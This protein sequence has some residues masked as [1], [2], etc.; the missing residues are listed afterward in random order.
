MTNRSPL[1]AYE[2][3]TNPRTVAL[4]GASSNEGRLTARPQIFMNRH[5]FQGTIY[6]V[7]PNRKSVLG[8]PAFADV[9]DIPVPV[10]L[11]YIMQDTDAAI[12][13]F[14]ACAAIGVRV[15]ILLANGFSEVGAE[16]VERERRIRETADKHGVFLIGPN[17]T[18]V[19]ATRS[20]LSCTT[21][22]AFSVDSLPVGNLAVLSQSGSLIGTL[23]SRGAPRGI[24][25]S[26]F[27]SV[28]N[29]A[30]QTIGSIGDL[31]VDDPDT[32][33]F[34]LFLETIRD[35]S[36]FAS[37]ARKAYE[38]RKPV[39]AYVVG[40]SDEGKALSASHTG[41]MTGSSKAMQAFLDDNGIYTVSILDAL[42]DG[43]ATAMKIGKREN[44]RPSTV[45]VASTTGGGGAMV[46][47]KLSN[48]GVSVAGCSDEARDILTSRNVPLGKGKLLDVTLAGTN[49]ETM[50]DVVS[51]LIEDPSTG[52]LLVV[53]GSSAQF[54]PELAVRP[55]VDAVAESSPNASPVLA[56]PL[57]EAVDSLR[58]LNV[59][60]I[61][62]FRT[63]ES[64]AEAIS[65]VLAHS[66]PRHLVHIERSDEV[67]NR[68]Q[69]CPAGTQSELKSMV[70]FEAAG[71][72]GPA[73]VM[74]ADFE[75][76]PRELPFSYPV[77]AKL[78][79]AE[80]T[81]KSDVGAVAL[82]ILNRTEL[83]ERCRGILNHVETFLPKSKI[84][85]FS[86]QEM[87]SGVCEVLLGLTR[88]PVV[89]P[90]VTLASGGVL[91]EIY[92]DICVRPAPVSNEAAAEMI[93][94]IVGLAPARGY[95][96]LPKGD[97]SAL[98][99]A[100]AA[101]STLAAYDEIAEAE[102]NPM[103]VRDEGNGVVMLDAL[104]RI[105]R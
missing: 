62:C 94:S 96:N 16:G 21:N 72:A 44:H 11:A 43:P 53:I 17:S 30:Q 5:G 60:G 1:G 99:D 10:D 58:L 45:T 81:H 78:V 59:H 70:I 34:L 65:T 76:I 61:P 40:A 103:L 47:D 68:I 13:S 87:C 57:P 50:K 25:F 7:N 52:V 66:P 36:A 63:V 98:A 4:I 20:G 19:V 82:G 26:S 39:F 51:T 32:S 91:A 92:K 95:R 80:I 69:D 24:G 28:G 77:A 102:I 8:L 41:A 67:A 73:R 35:R 6:R 3:I 22:A 83:V 12:E 86:I 42:L 88:D 37:F 49:Y 105:D 31:F 97:I 54:N 89:G 74:A 85:G 101:F 93:E 71:L 14:E 33:G 29:E 27:V 100:I 90:V 75:Q 23:L 79:S 9:S 18:G 38:Q 104:I 84:E 55:I 2:A 64:C 15:V 56:F 46:I 48:A